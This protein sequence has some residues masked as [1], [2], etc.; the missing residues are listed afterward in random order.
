MTAEMV[1]PA[2]MH[3]QISAEQY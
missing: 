2:W 1:A 3:T